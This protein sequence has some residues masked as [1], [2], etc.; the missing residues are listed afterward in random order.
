MGVAALLRVLYVTPFLFLTRRTRCVFL[1]ILSQL[2]LLG[3]RY[4]SSMLTGCGSDARGL[5]HLQNY[6]TLSLKRS[7]AHMDH[8]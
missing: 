6:F 3:K 5:F 2:V 1:H 7:S 8:F 4:C